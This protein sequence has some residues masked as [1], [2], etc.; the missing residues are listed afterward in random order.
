VEP[1]ALLDALVELAEAAGLEVRVL[2]RGAAREGEMLPTSGLCRLRGVWV[3][4]LAAGEPLEARIDAT[5][6]AV[7]G[8]G[9]ALL[10]E[11]FVAPAVRERIAA[12]V[13]EA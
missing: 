5:A 8:H 10:E 7:H 9:A 12:V 13:P 4:I 3:L 1:P 6:R 2:S 11:R